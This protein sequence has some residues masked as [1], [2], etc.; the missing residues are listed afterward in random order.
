MPEPFSV[1]GGDAPKCRFSVWCPHLLPLCCASVLSPFH[2]PCLCPQ[3]GCPGVV[4]FRSEGYGNPASFCNLLG[5]YRSLLLL[6][7]PGFL[8]RM[9]TLD[10]SSISVVP[11]PLVSSSKGQTGETGQRDA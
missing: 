1:T 4:Y 5:K 10:D 9:Y 8:L 11:Q 2:F 3:S 7:A 6:F